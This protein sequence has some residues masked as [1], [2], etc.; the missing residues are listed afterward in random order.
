M[1][2]WQ[3]HSR[4][5]A[6][7]RSMG[8]GHL[9]KFDGTRQMIKH[10]SAPGGPNVTNSIDQCPFSLSYITVNDAA[11]L[12]A[13]RSTLTLKVVPKRV[14]CLVPVHLK[15]RLLPGCFGRSKYHVDLRPTVGL[16]SSPAL[17]NQL[18]AALQFI[19][20]LN[21]IIDLI[22]YP[23]DF[24]SA[25]LPIRSATAIRMKTILAILDPVHP[26]SDGPANPPAT[27]VTLQ[28][29]PCDAIVC[30]CCCL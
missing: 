17:L 28:G 2:T 16:R 30:L 25:E 18:P 26:G 13:R 8:L 4:I 3:D 20:S 15:D 12:V 11:A 9:E 5:L 22:L 14:F 7:L 29:I 23:D 19:W 27:L 21:C 10:F 6:T 24:F 1:D